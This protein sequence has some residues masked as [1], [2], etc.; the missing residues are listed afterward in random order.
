M[1]VRTP[2][3]E[4]S[5]RFRHDK[6]HTIIAPPANI[7]LCAVG[8]RRRSNSKG[9]HRPHSDAMD[10]VHVLAPNTFYPIVA[11]WNR[12]ILDRCAAALRDG[13]TAV[14]L[15]A[16]NF[17]AAT[18]AVHHWSFSWGKTNRKKPSETPL[19]TLVPKAIPG[20]QLIALVLEEGGAGWRE[21]RPKPKGA[22]ARA[23]G[24]VGFRLLPRLKALVGL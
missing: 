3:L 13:E 21:A 2:I 16:D 19:R 11:K 23:R 4:L 14:D 1:Y 24:W 20:R 18:H 7:L 10:A 12:K 15:C 5:E 8:N 22:W 6:S 17:T 9:D